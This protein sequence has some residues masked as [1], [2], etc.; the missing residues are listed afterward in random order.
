MKK[1]VADTYSFEWRHNGLTI[2]AAAYLC[3]SLQ[4]SVRNEEPE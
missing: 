4:T 3:A 1:S 2:K